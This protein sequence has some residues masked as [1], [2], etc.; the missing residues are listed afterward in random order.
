MGYALFRGTAEVMLAIRGVLLA[1]LLG[2]AAFGTWALLR[3]VMRYSSLVGLSVYR[4][5]E[6]ELLRKKGRSP[7]APG[8]FAPAA[9][10]FVLLLSG[11][12][13]LVALTISFLVNEQAHRV[14]LRGFAAAGLAEALS[15]MPSCAPGSG[16]AS[17][18][19]L[20]SS[21][22]L[23]CCMWSAPLPWRRCGGWRGR[24]RRT[25]LGQ[26]P[27]NCCPGVTMAGAAA[28]HRPETGAADAG[29]RFAGGA[30]HGRGDRAGDR[31]P[32][33]RGDLGRPHHARVLRICRI[34]N[35][36]CRRFGP[37]G[38]YRSVSSGVRSPQFQR[39][40][41]RTTG[42]P[43][44]GLVALR[45]SAPPAPWRLSLVL[46]PVVLQAVP[47][48]R[49]AIAPGRVFL[50]SGV[51]MGLVNLASIGAVAAGRQRRLPLYAGSALVL[52]FALSIGALSGYGLGSVAAATF[53]GHLVF[54]ALV[55]RLNVREAGV[56]QP[57][58]FVATI[59]LP[60]VWCTLR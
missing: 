13:A 23:R 16:A 43:R 34:G 29:D 39:S 19:T 49:E 2:P 11:G 52:T 6:L 55:L 59:L 8:T 30:Q 58:R 50:L 1:V 35:H 7:A 37:G 12:L 45:P 41:C 17:G 5:L 44:A 46:G 47:S 33:G 18:S 38:T 24:L 15:A 54:A 20:F 26:P 31:R 3:L 60:L 56:T 4:G 10:G 14:V 48:Y 21:P 53:A 25:D 36:G 22:E 57:A 9:L 32:L 28:H 40:G 27:G 51:A 42:S